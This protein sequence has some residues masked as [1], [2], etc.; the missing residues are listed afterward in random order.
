M[1]KILIILL[2]SL[3]SQSCSSVPREIKRKFGLCYTGK[4]TDIESYIDINGYYTSSGQSGTI[5]FKDGIFANYVYLNPEIHASDTCVN[6]V[7]VTNRS[8]NNKPRID[9]PGLHKGMYWI[10]GDTIKVR[11][12]SHIGII[13]SG[14]SFDE[15]WYKIIDRQTLEAIYYK[16]LLDINA[17]YEEWRPKPNKERILYR[18][19][20]TDSVSTSD[21]WLKKEKWFWCNEQ[22]WKDYMEKIKQKKKKK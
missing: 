10:E 4:D 19:H 7:R 1:K 6:F 21:N 20:C 13:I 22:D 8:D 2:L 15:V 17:S 14:I 11:Y 16:S 18:F 5:F 9:A 12:L 3:I